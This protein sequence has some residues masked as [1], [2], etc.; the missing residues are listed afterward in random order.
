[1]RRQRFV[2]KCDVRKY[3]ASIDHHVLKGLLAAAVK[4]RP[5][6]R[7]AGS[8]IDGWERR[9]ETVHYFPGDT[10]FTPL[11]RRRGLPLGNQTS[12]FFANSLR[13]CSSTSGSRSRRSAEG[14]LR[15]TTRGPGSE[16]AASEAWPEPTSLATNRGISRS[17]VFGNFENFSNPT[18]S[19]HL[20]PILGL[21]RTSVQNS[22]PLHSNRNANLVEPL[23]H[24][25]GAGRLRPRR[26]APANS[27]PNG[28]NKGVSDASHSYFNRR[29]R[30]A[31]F[32]R[33]LATHFRLRH[34]VQRILTPPQSGHVV[35]YD[36]KMPEL[37][38]VYGDLPP[39]MHVKPGPNAPVGFGSAGPGFGALNSSSYT[40]VF[41]RPNPQVGMALPNR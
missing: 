20:A 35:H 32:S 31:R 18:H 39:V 37:K 21:R 9:D 36:L 28:K 41:R 4:C 17:Q 2:L 22:H 1:M 15:R 40:P 12:Q 24:S 6:L 27:F 34:N 8:I 19:N 14:C 25:S 38:T 33:F 26:D 13:V 23:A 29:P 7:L 3:F 5:T 30:M 11:E 10:L 16:V